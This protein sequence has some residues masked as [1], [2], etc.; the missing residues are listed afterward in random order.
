MPNGPSLAPAPQPCYAAPSLAAFKAA[1][2]EAYARFQVIAV[3]EAQFFPG[4]YVDTRMW[5][6]VWE[7]A[8]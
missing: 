3:D 5:W 6:C 7:G 2:G 4:V 1:A 8:Y